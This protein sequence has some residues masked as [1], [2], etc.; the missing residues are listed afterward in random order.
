VVKVA[1]LSLR[2]AAKHFE[3]SRPTLQKALSSGKIT[4]V[5]DSQGHWTIH[6]SELARVYP[7]RSE[8]GQAEHPSLPVKFTTANTP[9][10]IPDTG[11]LTALKARLDDAERRA[12]V[13]EALAEERG[14]HIEDLRRMLPSPAPARWLLARLLGR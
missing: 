13:A 9:Q 10:N 12:S 3:V 5:R 6:S 14:R 7:P 4:G 11:E 1:N 2:E 8:G